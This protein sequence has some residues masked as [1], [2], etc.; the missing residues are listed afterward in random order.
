MQVV[1][2]YALWNRRTDNRESRGVFLLYAKIIGIS[3]PVGILAE[4]FRRWAFT[5][6]D[7]IGYLKAFWICCTVGG[8]YCLLLAGGGYLMKI[9]EIKMLIQKLLHR[10]P[11]I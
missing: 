1:L 10:K 6:P 4:W 11:L 3:V 8:G 9:D 7:S 5:G 2:L